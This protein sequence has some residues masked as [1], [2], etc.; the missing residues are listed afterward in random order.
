MGANPGELDIAAH[1][2]AVSGRDKPDTDRLA[3]SM[4]RL[5]WPGG[6]SDRTERAALEWVRGWGPRCAGTIP[7]TCRCATGRC[8]VCN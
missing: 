5:S 3:S 7:P 4:L 2:E 8:G 1:I 6:M